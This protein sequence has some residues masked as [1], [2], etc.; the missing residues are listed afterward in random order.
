MTLTTVVDFRS[1]DG[2]VTLLCRERVPDGSTSNFRLLM[3]CSYTTNQVVV[4]KIFIFIKL[5]HTLLP[6]SARGTIDPVYLRNLSD[7]CLLT[8]N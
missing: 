5:S 2:N 8:Y 3:G 1:S 7:G 6:V 4:S